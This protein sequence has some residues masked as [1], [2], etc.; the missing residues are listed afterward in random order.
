MLT[1]AA[2]MDVDVNAA[3][4]VTPSAVALIEAAPAETAVT[5][6]DAE[7]VATAVLLEVHVIVR[8]VIATPC[9]S[10]GVAVS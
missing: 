5:S 3:W 6:P 10:F 1:D 7:T 2:V 4:P 8:P 9:A